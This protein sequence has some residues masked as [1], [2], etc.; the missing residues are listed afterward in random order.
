MRDAEGRKKEASTIII[1]Q[2]II[3]SCSPVASIVLSGSEWAQVVLSAMSK[4]VM[5][6]SVHNMFCFL[7]CVVAVLLGE[8]LELSL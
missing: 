1:I 5:G 2:N 3:F 6:S 4:V 8:G 7:V